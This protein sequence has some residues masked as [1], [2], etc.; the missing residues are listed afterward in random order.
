MENELSLREFGIQ[1]EDQEAFSA[2][3]IALRAHLEGDP[4]DCFAW[5]TLGNAYKVLGQFGNARAALEQALINAPDERRW[6]VMTARARVEKKS[7]HHKECEA[8]YERAFAESDFSEARWPHVLRG[9]NLLRLERFA[10]A[11]GSFRKATELSSEVD[12]DALDEAWHM[13]GVSLLAQ[14]RLEEAAEAFQRALE[15]NPQ[16][17]IS[18]K[19]LEGLKQVE[20]AHKMIADAPT[21]KVD[22]LV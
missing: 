17:E 15:V 11:E 12:D 7:G 6:V 13:L 1:C 4:T 2:A 18:R 14:E 21:P 20:V 22:K 10:E 9:A 16:S 19:Q 5:M 3:V 8:W